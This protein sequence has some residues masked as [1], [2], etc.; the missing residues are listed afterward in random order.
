MSQPAGATIIQQETD[1]RTFLLIQC[2][3]K[4]PVCDEYAKQAIVG[5][6]EHKRL[7]C[8]PAGGFT[9]ADTAEQKKLCMQTQATP[10]NLLLAQKTVLDQCKAQQAAANPPPAAGAGATGPGKVAGLNDNPIQGA[11][12]EQPPAA[13]DEAP[14]PAEDKAPAPADAAAPQACATVP[15]EAPAPDAGGGGG[16]PDGGQPDGGGEKPINKATTGPIEIE[17]VGV[18]PT[19]KEGVP[20]TFK[21]TI[22]NTSNQPIT[23]PLGFMDEPSVGGAILDTKI[24]GPWNC[25][26]GAKGIPCSREGPSLAGQD[27]LCHQFLCGILADCTIGTTCGRI[28]Q[29]P[30]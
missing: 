7:N 17:K 23:I 19:C 6:E 11:A 20:C 2:K 21:V 16:Q 15:T 13:G 4:S 5:G 8:G 30:G 24:D 26:L 3:A 22:T 27:L 25:G 9:S 29:P 12:E 1:A 18:S 28:A 10:E 14:A